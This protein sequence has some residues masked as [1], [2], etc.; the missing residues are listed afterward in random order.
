MLLPNIDLDFTLLEEDFE[1]FVREKL[2]ERESTFIQK[3]SIDIKAIL[4]NYHK[5]KNSS[6]I[7]SKLKLHFISLFKK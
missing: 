6:Q 2:K 5:L 7:S 3:K 1:K 4:K